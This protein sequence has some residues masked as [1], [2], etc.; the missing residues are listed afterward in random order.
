MC[1]RRQ[2]ISA[3]DCRWTFRRDNCDL[4]APGPDC[5]LSCQV[6][7][8]MTLVPIWTNKDMSIVREV[9]IKFSSL[10]HRNDHLLVMSGISALIEADFVCEVGAYEEVVSTSTNS[11]VHRQERIPLTCSP[12]QSRYRVTDSSYDRSRGLTVLQALTQETESASCVTVGRRFP[13]LRLNGVVFKSRCGRGLKSGLHNENTRFKWSQKSCH[14]ATKQQSVLV[15]VPHSRRVSISVSS[16][17]EK[18]KHIWLSSK[19]S[20]SSQA[21][22]V[23]HYCL[24]NERRFQC[25]NNLAQE[26]RKVI[27]LLETSQIISRSTF[28]VETIEKSHSEES[29]SDDWE[30]N[31]FS[32]VDS[33]FCSEESESSD[34][35][36]D[37]SQIHHELLRK[38]V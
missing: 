35:E 31:S 33:S 8:T 13:R 20:P 22:D 30:T 32:S 7:Q 18:P 5:V 10:Y 29:E 34:S 2:L 26:E 28:C 25:E 16:N 12:I 19:F 21:S 1:T 15:S 3:G 17:S 36:G 37:T 27:G 6:S 38:E 23:S 4:S 14:K 24:T 9:I 11:D